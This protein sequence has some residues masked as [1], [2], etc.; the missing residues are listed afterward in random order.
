MVP[1]LSIRSVATS[2]AASTARPEVART[3]W[4]TRRFMPAIPTAESRA[5]MVV[6]IRQTNRAIRDSGESS[7]PVKSPIGASAVTATRKRMVSVES[8]MLSAISFGV[9]RRSAPSTKAIMVSTKVEPGSEVI[10]TLMESE[11]TTVPP[12]TAQ[13]SPPASRTTGADSPVIADSSTVAAPSMTSPSPGMVS[14]AS[15][16]T[17]APL[18]SSDAGTT[19]MPESVMRLAVASSRTERRLSAWALPR[20]SA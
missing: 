20:P 11:S 14:P 2:P 6:G 18:V 3:L 1:V 13:R 17:M 12:V 4:R 10:L 19:S 5:A 16:R 9:L 15:T 7:A 8:R